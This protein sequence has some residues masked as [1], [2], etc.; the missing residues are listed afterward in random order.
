M[1]N[2]AS[3]GRSRN[4]IDDAACI[5]GVHVMIHEVSDHGHDDDYADNVQR[6]FRRLIYIL[7][8]DRLLSNYMNSIIIVNTENNQERG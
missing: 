8:E 2:L 6:T 1:E 5:A 7:Y 4:H 3:A